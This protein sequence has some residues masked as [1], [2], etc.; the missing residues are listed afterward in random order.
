M[1]Y[2]LVPR[3][4]SMLAVW[5]VLLAWHLGARAAGG[6]GSLFFLLLIALPLA[7]SGAE[8]ALYK[9]HAFRRACLSGD[10]WLYRLTGL[11][12][13]ILAVEAAKALALAALLMAATLSLQPREWA[14]LAVDVLVLALLMPRL[15]GLLHDA[16]NATYLY[17]LSRRL[18]VWF[19]TLLLWLESLLV[20]VL[21]N[22]DDY[23][24]LSWSQAL[25]Y[26]TAPTAATDDRSLISVL[27]RI[28]AGVNG[29]GSWAG[30]R[31]FHGCDD[32]AQ[33]MLALLVMGAVVALW[34]VVAWAY[35]RALVGALSRPL[36]IWRPRARRRQ[37]GD[38]FETWW[39]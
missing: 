27:V 26:S 6:F 4:L 20:L 7:M 32:P 10:S 15:P 25:A 16:V 1:K 21:A 12:P 39:I 31:L 2:R 24:G 28:D 29:A 33:A 34:F 11:V 18:A 30:Y 14:L 36:A 9:R 37:G 8:A 5:L 22:S 35:S 13:L 19:S 3:L 17:A 38:D 23:R